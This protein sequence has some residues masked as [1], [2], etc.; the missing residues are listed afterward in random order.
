MFK[1]KKIVAMVLCALM[2]FVPVAAMAAPAAPAAPDQHDYLGDFAGAAEETFPELGGAKGTYILAVQAAITAAAD[3]GAKDA[4]ETAL[5]GAVKDYEKKLEAAK[6]TLADAEALMNKVKGVKGG[7]EAYTGEA[8]GDRTKEQA[9]DLWETGM[10]TLEKT[11]ANFAAIV[12]EYKEY[13]NLYKAANDVLAQLQKDIDAANTLEKA[14]KA[15]DEAAQLYQHTNVKS[16]IRPFVE[17]AW[18][19]FVSFANDVQRVTKYDQLVAANKEI[20]EVLDAS[21]KKDYVASKEGWRVVNKN[22]GDYL[23]DVAKVEVVTKDGKSTVK[24]YD[25]AGKELKLDQTFY[26]WIPVSKDTKV[27]GAKVDGKETTFSVF[28]VDNQKYVEV[29][30]EF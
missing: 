23:K 1:N 11:R 3:Q 29:A 26:I 7:Y 9:K 19:K 2:L 12:A 6:K 4:A 30:A 17:S 14:E 21:A 10:A 25:A 8:F 24:L 22:K 5:K 13:A 18:K 16:V 15:L 20:A 28:T 27:L